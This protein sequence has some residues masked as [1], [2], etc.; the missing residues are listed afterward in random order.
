MGFL[1]NPYRFAVG[2]E[3][4]DADLKA[5]WFMGEPSGNLLNT[6]ES[7]AKISNSDLV[8][9]GTTGYN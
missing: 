8:T 3:I 7:S 9:S 5:L 2:S 6:S 1:I 4:S